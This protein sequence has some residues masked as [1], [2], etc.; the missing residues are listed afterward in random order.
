M[1]TLD[2]ISIKD[3]ERNAVIEASAMLREAFPVKEVVLFGSKARGDDDDESDID[4]LVLTSQPVS[5]SDRKAINNALY[6]IQIR[7][8]I[9][10]SPLITT[11]AEWNEGTYSVLPIHAEIS[12]QGVP[13]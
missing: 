8:D 6:E 13:A 4:L 1:N 12:A 3:N 7:Y 9:I 10:I 11:V 5:W 2:N